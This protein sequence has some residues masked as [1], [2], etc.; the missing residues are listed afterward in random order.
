MF[1]VKQVIG[2]DW[3]QYVFINIVTVSNSCEHLAFIFPYNLLLRYVCG[4]LRDTNSDLH[5]RHTRDVHSV[6]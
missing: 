2:R 5:H 6:T 1:G 4:A 3:T